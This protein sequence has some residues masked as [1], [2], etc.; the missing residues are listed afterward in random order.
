M[1]FLVISLLFTHQLAFAQNC[2]S[3]AVDKFCKN[4]RM[5]ISFKSQDLREA[6]SYGGNLALKHSNIE[7]L[8]EL[9]EEKYDASTDEAF[10]SPDVYSG[11]VKKNQQCM[12][13]AETFAGC[14]KPN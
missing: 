3:E 5:G 2:T 9:C 7:E 10:S 8:I 6:C 13:G 12:L 11:L 14:K 4:K 1:K